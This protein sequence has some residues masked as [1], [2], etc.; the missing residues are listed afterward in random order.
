[1]S[2]PSAP[3]TQMFSVDVNGETVAE[4]WNKA[5]PMPAHLAERVDTLSKRHHSTSPTDMENKMEKAQQNYKENLKNTRSKAHIA[6]AKGVKAKE[7][8]AEFG[9]NMSMMGNAMGNKDEST[10]L[11]KS[12]ASRVE[13][14]APAP[15]TKDSLMSKQDKAA[16][17]RKAA[18]EK[19][20]LKASAASTKIAAAKARKEAE[21]R[22]AQSATGKFF[23]V[24]AGIETNT[25]NGGWGAKVPLPT[26]LSER[27]KEGECERRSEGGSF[28]VVVNG[29][30]VCFNGCYYCFSL[31]IFLSCLLTYFFFFLSLFFVL[32]FQLFH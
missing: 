32:H 3:T 14:L 10:K 29:C 15:T 5:V 21:F 20:Q 8:R 6:T 9:E 7:R 17:N 24:D 23:E 11:P 2:N 19:K 4:T 13:S 26:H 28:T 1:M 25:S 18:N 16:A 31:F 12:L 27:V 30:W 22:E